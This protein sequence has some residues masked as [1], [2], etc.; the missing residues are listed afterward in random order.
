MNDKKNSG[1][2]KKPQS[3]ANPEVPAKDKEQTSGNLPPISKQTAGGVA[4]AMVGG[5]VAGPI[6]ALVGGVAG[7]LVGN[8]S[9]A[10]ERPIGKTVDT[11]R[12]VAEEPARKVYKRITNSGTPKVAK[13]E[14]SK[15]DAQTKKALTK[16]VLAK[17]TAAKKASGRSKSER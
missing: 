13:Q 15:K 3:A 8:A 9:A 1:P 11:I 12:A 10:G 16:K 4:G 17:K 7:A 6:G 2:S 5:V 14:V